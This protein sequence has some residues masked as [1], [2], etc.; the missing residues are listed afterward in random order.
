MP[1]FSLDSVT[2]RIPPTIYYQTSRRPQLINVRLAGRDIAETRAAI[3]ALWKRMGNGHPL[4]QFFLDEHLERHYQSVLRQ[5]QAFGICALIAVALSCVGLFA[6]T[7]AAAQRRTR[8]IG[9]RKA[10]GANTADVLR[11]LLWQFSKPVMWGSL[12]AWVTAAYTMHRWLAGFAYHID[13]PLVLFPGAALAALVIALATVTA[14]SCWS[15]VPNPST[16]CG[17]NRKR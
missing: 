4:L 9:I 8:E 17:T 5:S 13:L 6:L 1:D 3:D 7:A 15:R 2:E 16:R 11:L 12:L 10:L 14:Q